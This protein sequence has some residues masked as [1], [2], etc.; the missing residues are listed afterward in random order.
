MR[1]LL[2]AIIVLSLVS[3]LLTGCWDGREPQN[4]THAVL[5]AFD[6][7]DQGNY[8]ALVQFPGPAV[9]GGGGGE[10]GGAGGDGGK[11][12]FCTNS[13]KG[14]TPFAAI[15]N[16]SPTTSRLT[17]LSHLRILLISEKL[18]R[19]GIG[20]VIDLLEKDRE[21][22][23]SL[24][25]AVVE[26]DLK[27]LLTAPF[28]LESTPAMGLE[29][30]V[31]FS[32]YE[33]SITPNAPFLD[34]LRELTRPGEEMLL[35]RIEV[36]PTEPAAAEKPAQGDQSPAGSPKPPALVAG[37]AVFQGEK[38]VDW[39]D[40]DATRGWMLIKGKAQRGP[41]VVKSPDGEGYIT[42][43]IFNSQATL[44]PVVQD[45]KVRMQ[46]KVT[47]H[48]RVQDQTSARGDLSSLDW[49]NPQMLNL[50]KNNFA[51]VIRGC[52]EVSLARAQKLGVDVFGCGNAVYRKH[53]H[54]WEKIGER[55]PEIFPTI[56]VD[57]T[58][59]TMI[60][61]PGRIR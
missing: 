14:E 34:S 60:H 23:L 40:I 17:S 39:F 1:R 37:G 6:I 58:V 5:L 48:G 45:G 57:I 46:V 2:K 4:L 32:K 24:H 52:I 3:F 10:G 12:P 8:E 16:L 31:R 28:P 42:I 35:A 50:L 61:R 56:P 9:T 29:H 15:R 38:M 49:Q 25:V 33:R 54:E 43:N 26:G 20:A 59:K 36:L 27:Q 19:H 53:P 18:A 22:R 7:D 30:L 44:T 41:V 11:S 47:V 21:L 55:W 51:E 13:A